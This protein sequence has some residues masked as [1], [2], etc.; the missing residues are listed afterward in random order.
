MM[1]DAEA[2]INEDTEQAKRKLEKE[3]VGLVSEATEVIVDEKVDAKKDASLIA[4][5]LKGQGK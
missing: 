5:A 2:R 1:T 4:K 3:I